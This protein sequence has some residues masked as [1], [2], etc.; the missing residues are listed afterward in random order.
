MRMGMQTRGAKSPSKVDDTEAPVWRVLQEIISHWGPLLYIQS[1][2][3]IT[4]LQEIFLKI[5]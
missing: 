3:F 4:T 2:L 5:D 1:P